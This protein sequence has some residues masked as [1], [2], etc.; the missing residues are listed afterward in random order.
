V[1][2]KII[3]IYSEKDIQGEKF[4]ER[5]SDILMDSI[6]LAIFHEKACPELERKSV[7]DEENFATESSNRTIVLFPNFL[8]GETCSCLEPT[9]W[10]NLFREICLY[11]N[12]NS[13]EL[14]KK[15]ERNLNE[16]MYQSLFKN[17]AR[18]LVNKRKTICLLVMCA[19]VSRSD[20][21]ILMRK[22]E[23]G[24][25]II[26]QVQ[27][28]HDLLESATIPLSKKDVKTSACCTVS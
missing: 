17:L 3:I 12:I 21:A 22:S 5:I 26:K 16:P 9:M 1:I 20:I 6:K 14:T 25:S 19:E 15:C 28:E 8:A 2:Y 4:R 23:F 11:L 27:D 7:L 24:E 18:H 10:K 13:S